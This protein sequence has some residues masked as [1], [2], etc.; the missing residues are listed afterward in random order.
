MDVTA[1]LWSTLIVIELVQPYRRSEAA[2]I[3]FEFFFLLLYTR[4]LWSDLA[5]RFPLRRSGP[6]WSISPYRKCRSAFLLLLYEDGDGCREDVGASLLFL[7]SE[8]WT[9]GLTHWLPSASDRLR[10]TNCVFS[11][12][13][14]LFPQQWKNLFGHWLADQYSTWYVSVLAVQ[15]SLPVDELRHLSLAFL[16]YITHSNAVAVPN[17]FLVTEGWLAKRYA[18]CLFRYRDFAQHTLHLIHDSTRVNHLWCVK[19]ITSLSFDI[20]SIATRRRILHSPLSWLAD[21]RR[22]VT[23]LWSVYMNWRG[24]LSVF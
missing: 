4:A 22:L 1:I 13:C 23:L 8:K 5:T 16:Y 10:P 7:S 14:W 20:K 2:R 21:C 6:H 9:K 12:L 17:S 18:T 19:W 15:S 11:A 3:F 24:Q